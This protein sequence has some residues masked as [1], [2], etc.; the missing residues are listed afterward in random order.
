MRVLD[1]D[2][3]LARALTSLGCGIVVGPATP[4]VLTRVDLVAMPPHWGLLRDWREAGAR[5]PVLVVVPTQ[6]DDLTALQPLAVVRSGEPAVLRQAL[7]ALDLGRAAGRIVLDGVRVD[8]ETRQVRRGSTT[9]RLT[10]READLLAYLAAREREVERDEL[11]VQV[12]GHVRPTS[13]RAVD[14]AMLRLR[15]KIE[16]DP[17]LPR[18]LLSS[19]GGGYRLVLPGP[20][21]RVLE[22]YRTSAELLLQHGRPREALALLDQHEAARSPDDARGAVLHDVLACRAR[23]ALGELPQ[24]IEHGEHGLAVARQHGLESLEAAV[25][26]ALAAVLRPTG[27]AGRARDLAS[28]SL[29]LAT[30]LQQPVGQA[31]ALS[32]LADLGHGAEA[33]ALAQR[34]LDALQQASAPERTGL[35]AQSLHGALRLRIARGLTL[36][37]RPRDALEHLEH[38]VR[39]H[40]LLGKVRVEGQARIAI[41]A[42]WF[43]L[44]ELEA[45]DEPLQRGLEVLRR[46]EAPRALAHGLVFQAGV[47]FTAGRIAQALVVLDEIRTLHGE[48]GTAATAAADA[49]HAACMLVSGDVEG[50]RRGADAIVVS[51]GA[52]EPIAYY[53]AVLQAAC[54]PTATERSAAL[55]RL[56]SDPPD[57]PLVRAFR[58][59]L[60]R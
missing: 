41:A 30:H 21:D 1:L 17:A 60:D 50:A 26:C 48:R 16:P 8:L 7:R 2:S 15:K 28:R 27:A 46:G 9:T 11:L 43:E 52:H 33:L 5:V 49:L 47:D 57:N 53:R 4:E 20:D 44:G 32:M 59:L 54:A 12:W 19:Y 37:G 40:E 51:D 13:L 14:M 31:R 24:A 6:P 25:G 10:Q 36:S 45:V 3:G 29:E 55:E 23:F 18:F 42:T 38:A 22:T 56:P 39:I 34:A 35:G 58:G